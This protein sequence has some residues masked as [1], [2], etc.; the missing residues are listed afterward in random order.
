[1][2]YSLLVYLLGGK[3]KTSVVKDGPEGCYQKTKGEGAK[4]TTVNFRMDN[5]GTPKLDG[6][7]PYIVNKNGT[8]LA[9]PLT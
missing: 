3:P 1:M 5:S 6:V 9:S 8:N 2:R 7:K 4:L